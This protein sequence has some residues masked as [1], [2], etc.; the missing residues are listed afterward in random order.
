[1]KENKII[2]EFI[3]ILEVSKLTIWKNLRKF[4]LILYKKWWVKKIQH[5]TRISQVFSNY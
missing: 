4:W 1:M 2:E 3:V 5:C